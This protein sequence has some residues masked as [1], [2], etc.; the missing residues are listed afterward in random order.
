MTR[1]AEPFCY[2]MHTAGEPSAVPFP[3]TRRDSRGLAGAT[4]LYASQPRPKAR[5]KPAGQFNADVE[6]QHILPPSRCRSVSVYSSLPDVE[7][8]QVVEHKMR[9]AAPAHNQIR[10]QV[11]TTYDQL[12]HAYAIRGICF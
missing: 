7:R 6:A 12:L 2:F 4:C 9:T 5:R 1:F 3:R 11:V 8:R 10:P